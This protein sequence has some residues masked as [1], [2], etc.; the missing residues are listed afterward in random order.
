MMT[1]PTE[2]PIIA[3]LPSAFLLDLVT[4]LEAPLTVEAAEL[5]VSTGWVTSLP[6]VLAPLSTS[7]A[8]LEGSVTSLAADLAVSVTL[9]A[10]E[11][12]APVVVSVTLSRP[13]VSVNLLWARLSPTVE[14]A[15]STPSTTELWVAA[16]PIE[17]AVSLTVL[18]TL[19]AKTS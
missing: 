5:A 17:E 4:D 13:V 3:P 9:P 12:T 16:S 18:V 15:P 19:E 14:A 6:T 8:S 1:A 2:M 10:A 11:E 7:E